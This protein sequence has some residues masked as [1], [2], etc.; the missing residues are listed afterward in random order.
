MKIFGLVLQLTRDLWNTGKSIIMDSNF[1]S[2][3]GVFE[4]SKREGYGS[5]LIKKIRYW[6]RGV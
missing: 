6:Y 2:L 4:M 1:C 5:E 3:K